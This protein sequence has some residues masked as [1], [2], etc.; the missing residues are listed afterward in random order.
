M[1]QVHSGIDSVR[2]EKSK[3][4]DLEHKTTSF[5]YQDYLKDAKMA[6]TANMNNIGRHTNR[7]LD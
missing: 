4:T 6:R 5:K 3:V 2:V 1:R 7:D